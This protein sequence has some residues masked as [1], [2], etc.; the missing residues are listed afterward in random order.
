MAW[1]TRQGQRI[2]DYQSKREI[3]LALE[4][5]AAGENWQVMRQDVQ[6]GHIEMCVQTGPKISPQNA[7][8]ILKLGASTIMDKNRPT[9][10]DGLRA[11]GFLAVTD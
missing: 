5:T 4:E 6:P 8:T 7:I 11:G 9:N 3:R 2:L 10:P 1:S